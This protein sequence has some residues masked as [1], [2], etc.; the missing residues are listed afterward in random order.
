RAAINPASGDTPA[1]FGLIDGNAWQV[2]LQLE[3]VAFTLI[4]SGVAT[5][6]ILKVLD[7]V[8]GLRVDLETERDGLD[9]ALHGETVQ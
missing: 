3:G 1:K 8:M 4:Y 7:L 5:L 9:L 2:V 6:I